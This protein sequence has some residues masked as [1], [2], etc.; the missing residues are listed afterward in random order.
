MT[1]FDY[2]ALVCVNIVVFTVVFGFIYI[3]RNIKDEERKRKEFENRIKPGTTFICHYSFDNPFL[4]PVTCRLKILDVKDGWVKYEEEN[5]GNI[6]YMKISSLYIS[7]FEIE[8]I[9]ENH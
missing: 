3:K 9:E 7:E 1:L 6:D 5:S 4:E 2:V 8:N